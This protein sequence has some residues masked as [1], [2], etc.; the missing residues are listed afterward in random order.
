MELSFEKKLKIHCKMKRIKLKDI[1]DHLEITSQELHN[2]L[3]G[4]QASIPSKGIEDVEQLKTAIR[5]HLS[6]NF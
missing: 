6:L 5:K 3:N 2:I 4:F 1:A